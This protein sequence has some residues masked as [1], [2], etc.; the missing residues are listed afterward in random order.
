MAFHRNEHEKISGKS[1]LNSNNPGAVLINRKR[2]AIYKLYRPYKKNLWK[3]QSHT[4][5][6]CP[7]SKLTFSQD[8]DPR[9]T[10]CQE[11]KSL[12]K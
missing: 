11:L 4:G 1:P 3:S 7:E 8:N 2:Q 5:K 12:L 10:Y 9:A 6:E